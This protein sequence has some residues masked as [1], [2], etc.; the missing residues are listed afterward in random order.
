MKLNII[1]CVGETALERR[2]KMTKKVIAKQLR[3]ALFSLRNKLKRNLQRLVIAYEPVWAIGTGKNATTE[4]ITDIHNY[5][6][7]SL[8]NIFGRNSLKI[9]I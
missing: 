1:L 6:A 9:K 2:K 3:T 8:S 7:K 5:I 4:Q